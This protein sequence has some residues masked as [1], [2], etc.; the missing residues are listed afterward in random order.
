MVAYCHCNAQSTNPFHARW[1]PLQEVS[2]SSPASRRERR[3]SPFHL[4]PP[5]KTTSDWPLAPTLVA[6]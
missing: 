3:S 6:E 4:A 2:K 1:N 5:A